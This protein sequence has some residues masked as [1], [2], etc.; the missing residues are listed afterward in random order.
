[1]LVNKGAR[2]TP[3]QVQMLTASITDARG[4]AVLQRASGK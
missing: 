3:A 1:V 2:L 4:K